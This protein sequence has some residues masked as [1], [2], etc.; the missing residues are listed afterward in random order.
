MESNLILPVALPLEV[1]H[2]TSV[3]QAFDYSKDI[4]VKPVVRNLSDLSFPVVGRVTDNLLGE[5]K[6]TLM[7]RRAVRS[8]CKILGIP[9]PFA[10][11]IPKDL[12]LTNITRLQ[13]ENADKSV[14]FLCRPDGVIANVLK[15]KYN[16]VP[17]QDILGALLHRDEVKYVNIG[18]NLLTVCLAFDETHVADPLS[19]DPENFLYAGTF[20]Y[21]SILGYTPLKAQAGLYRTACQNSFVGVS[22]GRIKAD[23]KLDRESRVLEFVNR[24]QCFDSAIVSRMLEQLAPERKRVL[25]THELA[26]FWTKLKGIVGLTEADT[27]IG[28]S[29]TSRKTL[30]D[31]VAL[32]KKR[33]KTSRLLGESVLDPVLSDR[34]AFDLINKVTTYSQ[35]LEEEEKY[36]TEVFAGKMLEAYFLN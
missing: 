24:L 5:F 21:A 33:N 16:E 23:Y 2:T 7:T 35:E 18:E 4:V 22:L 36:K 31:S 10:N 32:W 34:D 3:A 1:M 27:I 14:T 26:S 12:L 9:D 25:Y 13:K 19:T 20:L 15:K 17:Y 28:Y 8:L 6:D 11:Q 30:V 29:E